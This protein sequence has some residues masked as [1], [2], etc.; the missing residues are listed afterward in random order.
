MGVGE[1]DKPASHAGSFL[2]SPIV[3]AVGHGEMKEGGDA[4]VKVKT[5]KGVL[6]VSAMGGRI[7]AP[8]GKGSNA[9]D[10]ARLVADEVADREEAAVEVLQRAVRGWRARRQMQR[11]KD[12]KAAK[13]A[14]AAAEAAKA[15]AAAAEAAEAEAAA[16]AKA[17]EEAAKEAEEAKRSGRGGEGGGGARGGGAGGVARLSS[18]SP[19]CRRLPRRLP[20]PPHRQQCHCTSPAPAEPGG[21]GD[22][23]DDAEEEGP[24]RPRQ[25]VH[26]RRRR[27]APTRPS[28]LPSRARWRGCRE[29]G[30]ARS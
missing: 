13:E 1:W 12:E 20:Q 5:V 18:A 27:R 10:M 14:E 23:E 9:K 2:D 6:A 15:A 7:M 17:A 24:Y 25:R 28:L 30:R 4:D 8:V 3:I 19:P 21:G 11:R 26:R 22:D 16:K 29:H